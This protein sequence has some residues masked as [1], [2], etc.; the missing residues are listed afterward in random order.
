MWIVFLCSWCLHMLFILKWIPH[1][2]WRRNLSCIFVNFE[3]H[4]SVYIWTHVNKGLA[5]K[6]VFFFVFC[7]LF[8]SFVLK[9]WGNE[10]F[11]SFTGRSLINSEIF[12]NRGG[13]YLFCLYQKECF[14]LIQTEAIK[15]F[16]L[17][18][19]LYLYIKRETISAND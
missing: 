8:V 1:G 11:V 19:L 16:Y 4:I 15:Y 13:R 9:V 18:F 10:P 2:R 17:T 7:F 6:N 5:N 3:R 12:S 14:L